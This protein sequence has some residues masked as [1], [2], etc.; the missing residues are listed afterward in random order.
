VKNNFDV[1]IVGMGPSGLVLAGLLVNYGIE[2]GIF[3]RNKSTVTEPRAVSIDDESLRILQSFSLHKAVLK[4]VSQNYGSYY[5]DAKGKLFLKVEPNSFENGFFKRN[6]FD[7]P[8]FE[9]TLRKHLEKQNN[10]SINFSHTL[11][12][13]KN[14]TNRVTANFTDSKGLKRRFSAQYLVGCDGG[15][16]TVR[17]L[18]GATMKGSSFNQRWLVVDI[19]K[20]KNFFRHTEVYCNPKRSSI[21]L[22]G[23]FGIRRY[24][25]QLNDGENSEKLS[26]A[27]IRKLI[28][29]VGED[30]KAKI[31]RSQVYQFHALISSTWKKKSVAIAGDA[32]HL[33]P[34]FAGQ[35]M[36]SGIRDVGNLGW[37]LA[38][39]IK[40]PKSKDILETYYPE[41]K[42][43]CWALINLAIRMGKIMMP[44]TRFSS[45]LNASLFRL[46]KKNKALLSYVSQMKYRPKPKI[47]KGIVFFHGK[48][49]R[50]DKKLIGTLFPQPLVQDIKGAESYLDDV[51]GNKFSLVC[52]VKRYETYIRLEKCLNELSKLCKVV[53]LLHQ[54]CMIFPSKHVVV[55][56]TNNLLEKTDL[57]VPEDS[58]FLIRPDKLVSAIYKKNNLHY[59]SDLLNNNE[60]F[61]F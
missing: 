33:S 9:K 21:T 57:R 4:N 20:T 32:A 16:S 43:H 34:P 25:F 40:K 52:Y 44:K 24:E 6:A 19:Y 12:S 35:G 13:I 5:Y 27:F 7:Q 54:S 29:S 58:I 39:A 48:E 8:T 17:D 47:T 22:P 59:L 61:S 37:K 56:D 23:P 31:R 18:I 38:L 55:R 11:A 14:E 36:N 53:V 49:T 1:I 2:V 3:E 41:R 50:N 26:E 45:F 42:E 28:A 10:I 30:G 46:I 51:L 15:Q 60:I